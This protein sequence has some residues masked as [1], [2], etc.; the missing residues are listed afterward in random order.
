MKR[1]NTNFSMI[2]EESK[3]SDTTETTTQPPTEEEEVGVDPED[4]RVHHKPK[5]KKNK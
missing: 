4:K 5:R 1:D 2:R 3:K